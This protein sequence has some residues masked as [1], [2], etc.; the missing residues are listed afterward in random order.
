MVTLHALAILQIGKGQET[1]VGQGARPG[2][3]QV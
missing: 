3:E 1:N 2:P